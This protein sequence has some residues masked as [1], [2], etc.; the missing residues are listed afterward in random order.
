MKLKAA[1]SYITTIALHTL[2]SMIIILHDMFDAIHIMKFSFLP[3]Y[4]ESKS[5]D[6]QYQFLLNVEKHLFLSLQ[7]KMTLW[8]RA[9]LL[10]KISFLYYVRFVGM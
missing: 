2:V 6:R 8:L 5:Q 1:I 7:L 4:N 10:M 9:T 3:P